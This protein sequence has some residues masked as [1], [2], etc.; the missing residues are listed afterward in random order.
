MARILVQTDNRRTVLD[1]P[2]FDPR[3]IEGEQAER[4][5]GRLKRA[6]AE[7]EERRP[8]RRRVR[9]LATIV[10]ASHYRDVYG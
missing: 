10:P 9:R 2:A 7:A 5:V 1:E 6:V 8:R 4:L 3:E